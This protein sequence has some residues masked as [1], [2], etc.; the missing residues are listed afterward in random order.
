MASAHPPLRPFARGGVAAPTGP[1]AAALDRRAIERLGVPKAV[2]ME[3]AGRAAAAVL[4]RLFPTGTVVG[5]VGAGNNGG[6][7]LVLLRTVMAWGREVRGV[8]AADR[9]ADDPLLHGWPVPLAHDTDLG[10]AALARLLASAAVVVDGVLGTGASGA[11]R[12]RQAAAITSMNA[13]R[14]PVLAVDVP[15]GID[16]STGA[17][18]G[19]ATRADVTVSFGAPKLGTLLH[20]ARALVGRLVAVDIA[21][22][23]LEASECGALVATPAW[24]RE[25]LPLRG[26]ETHK[27][28]IGS[29]LIAAGRVGMAGAAVLAARASFR[30]GVGLVRVCSFP[31]NR[32]VLQSAVPEAIWIDASD[33]SA[34]RA[35]LEQSD[36]LAAGP[37]LGTDDAA[38]TL[39]GT[40]LSG[41]ARPTLLDADALNLAAAGRF[42]LAKTARERP[43][44]ITPHPGEMGRLAAAVG[45]STPVDPASTAR[46][47][48]KRLGCAV[49]LKGAPSLVASPD[50]PLLVDTQSS[51]D[52]A[53]AGMGDA[54]TG[55]AGALLAQGLD[56]RTAGAIGLYLTGRAARIAGRGA[57]L[58][59]SDVVRHLADALVEQGE[60]VN[61]LALPFVTFDADAAR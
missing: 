14:R 45:G 33:G 10:E 41:P 57:A 50:G 27:K 61:D 12:E 38:S 26:T 54:L 17:V 32:E 28:A 56:P 8:I 47:A 22:P 1:E 6:D 7:A 39:L 30:A 11:P 36:A 60:F 52:L 25:R 40:L 29:L 19:A 16:A 18:P 51:S 21:F 24:A 59:P 5:L 2:L 4:D 15:S 49:L 35:A 9:P 43:L 20:P 48:A 42:D 3:N 13:A 23:P 37:G 55:V 46:A 44:L 31:A 58:I 53:V 34:V